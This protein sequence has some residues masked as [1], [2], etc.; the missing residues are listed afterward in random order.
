MHAALG[1]DAAIQLL[2]EGLNALLVLLA[3]IQADALVHLVPGRQEGLGVAGSCGLL[4][5]LPQFLAATNVVIVH[6]CSP[7][8]PQANK[9]RTLFLSGL[10]PPCGFTLG[11]A[12]GAGAAAMSRSCAARV[13]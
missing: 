2:L 5:H 11:V 4:E 7:F 3:K 13:F 6:H 8:A 9:L 1:Q 10:P 12:P